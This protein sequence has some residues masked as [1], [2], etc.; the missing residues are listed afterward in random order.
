MSPWLCPLNMNPESR[1]CTIEYPNGSTDNAAL[2]KDLGGGLYQLLLDPHSFM[3]ADSEEELE[4]LPKYMDIIRAEE[5]AADRLKFVEIHE[6][7]NFQLFDF[8]ISQSIIDHPGLG[9]VFRRVR[10]EGG[11]GERVMGGLLLFYLAKDS[12]YDPTSDIESLHEKAR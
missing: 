6:R 5:V 8:L 4:L 3:L 11:Y 9:G 7:S 10:D 1:E 12:S 2:V